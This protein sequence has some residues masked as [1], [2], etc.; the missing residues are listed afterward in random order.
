MHFVVDVDEDN[1]GYVWIKDIAEKDSW[2]VN[3]V[4]FE[5]VTPAEELGPYMVIETTDY[6]S[7]EKESDELC[8]FWKDRHPHAKEAAE[9]ECD[10]LNTEWRKKQNNG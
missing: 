2:L 10:R 8:L 1:T 6:W 7:V 5:L 9:T 4:F 3:A